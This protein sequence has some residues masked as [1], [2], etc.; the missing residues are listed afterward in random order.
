MLESRQDWILDMIRRASE[1]LAALLAPVTPGARPVEDAQ[2]LDRALDDVFSG[3]GAHA[4][5]LDPE[6]VHAVLR[7]GDRVLLFAILQA[8]K[9]LA[10]DDDSGP[11]R[12]RCARALLERLAADPDQDPTIADAAR[13]L[14]AALAD[15]TA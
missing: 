1:A 11:A 15:L 4:H 7:R 9:A 12:L 10:A 8:R 2:D 5:L 13:P 3:L 14:A 6:T